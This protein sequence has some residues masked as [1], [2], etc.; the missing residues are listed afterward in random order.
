[1]AP[2]QRLLPQPSEEEMHSSHDSSSEASTTRQPLIQPANNNNSQTNNERPRITKQA[3]SVEDSDIARE[4]HDF[5]NLIALVRAK[6]N[7]DKKPARARSLVCLLVCKECRFKPLHSKPKHAFLSH[8]FAFSCLFFFKLFT[9]QLFVIAAT[10]VDWDLPL[11]F[12]GY[13]AEAAFNGEY[14][15]WTWGVCI[16]LAKSLYCCVCA[17]VYLLTNACFCHCLFVADEYGVL[18][19]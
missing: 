13:G 6:H 18:Y 15:W 7:G 11:L 10:A 3:S 8:T 9:R 19:Y 2:R 1:M 12:Q 5:F 14:F 16:Q 4:R 17:L